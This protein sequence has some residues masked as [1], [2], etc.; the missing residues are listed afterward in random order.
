MD[1]IEIKK[2]IHGGRLKSKGITIDRCI[3]VTF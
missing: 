2:N 3:A 1:R